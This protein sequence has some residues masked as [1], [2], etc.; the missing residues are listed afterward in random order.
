MFWS[1]KVPQSLQQKMFVTPVP[2]LASGLTQALA[3]HGPQARVTVM[4]WGPYVLP[5]V[6]K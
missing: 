2:S 4:P 3:K 5:Y 1:D 6:E